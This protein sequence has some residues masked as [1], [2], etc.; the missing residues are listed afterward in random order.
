MV[1]GEIQYIIDYAIVTVL[2]TSTFKHS[3]IGLLFFILYH[4]IL[5]NHSSLSSII[6]SPGNNNV[7]IQVVIYQFFCFDE[8]A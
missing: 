8:S 2:R 5:V 1:S 6:V 4:N 3:N 7:E